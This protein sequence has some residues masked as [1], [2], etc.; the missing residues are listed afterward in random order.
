[1]L[2]SRFLYFVFGSIS[3]LI[4]EVV[5]LL[6]FRTSSDIDND[7]IN[8][9]EASNYIRPFQ[10]IIEKSIK[11]VD[12][13]IQIDASLYKRENLFSFFYVTNDGVIIFRITKSNQ[14]VVFIPEE[15][16]GEIVWK[17]LGSPQT[18]VPLECRAR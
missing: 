16:E 7:R 11:D 13:K 8:F 9:G 14:L 12:S 18:T 1:M 17:C 5:L 2:K 15:N 3:I 10:E 4:I 6:V